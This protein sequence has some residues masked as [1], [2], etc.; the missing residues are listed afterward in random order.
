VDNIQITESEYIDQI[1]N[2]SK[3]FL[4][5][6]LFSL[7][8]EEINDCYRQSIY[9]YFLVSSYK[10]N[11]LYFFYSFLQLTSCRSN[12]YFLSFFIILFFSLPHALSYYFGSG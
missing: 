11:N 4:D 10:D 3:D 1:L 5:P 7:E 2:T 6:N 9:V 12:A 8:L